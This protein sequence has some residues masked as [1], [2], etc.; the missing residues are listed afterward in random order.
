MPIVRATKEK[1]VIEVLGTGFFVGSG[2]ALHVIT[3]KH[4]I[5]DNPVTGD[6]KYAIVFRDDKRIKILATLRILAAVDFDLAACVVDR[7][8]FPDAVPLQLLPALWEGA[9]TVRGCTMS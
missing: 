3:A 7:S 9:S 5:A 6:E 1:P 8:D 2:S 4:V